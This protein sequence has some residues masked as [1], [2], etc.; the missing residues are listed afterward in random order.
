M[1]DLRNNKPNHDSSIITEVHGPQVCL[2]K[3]EKDKYGMH[4]P[5]VWRDF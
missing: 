3:L 4:H 1:K 2:M 5:I